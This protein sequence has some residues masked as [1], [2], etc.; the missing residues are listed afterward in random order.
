MKIEFDGPNWTY[1][2]ETARELLS[3]AFLA[4]A[5]Y[6]YRIG[7]R[8]AP[9]PAP[10]PED[11]SWQDET[12]EVSRYRELKG[13]ITQ[14]QQRERERTGRGVPKRTDTDEDAD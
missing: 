4:P 7:T 8:I 11:T 13:V 2:R 10:P 9:P 14:T 6:L 12:P 3:L 1:L 5:A